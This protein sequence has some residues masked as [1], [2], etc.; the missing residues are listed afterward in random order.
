MLSI[1][2][3]KLYKKLS[4]C[5]TARC[6]CAIRNGMPDP[7]KRAPPNMCYYFEPGCSTSKSVG[8]SRGEPPKLGHQR[9]GPRPDTRGFNRFITPHKYTFLT[10]VIMPNLI[11]VSLTVRA[12]IW[13]Q[14]SAGKKLGTLHP[15][16]QGHSM[17]TAQT[18]T[19]RVYL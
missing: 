14:R 10:W 5:L 7:L 13:G 16:F 8:I 6:I 15:A 3:V 11:A 9:A 4:Y 1:N 18:R 12:Y 2:S 19:D 17:S